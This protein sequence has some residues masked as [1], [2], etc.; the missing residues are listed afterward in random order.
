MSKYH[1]TCGCC[2]QSFDTDHKG[3]RYC[4]ACPPSVREAKVKG[5]W[6]VEIPCSQCGASFLPLMKK[7]K[8]CGSACRIAYFSARQATQKN[9][10]SRRHCVVC[11][12]VFQPDTRAAVC[13]SDA[14]ACRKSGTVTAGA[15]C[16]V[17]GTAFRPF[18]SDRVCCSAACGAA[19]ARKRRDKASQCVECGAAFV[20]SASGVALRCATCKAG[21]RQRKKRSEVPCAC[22]GKPF[23]HVNATARFCSRKCS[24]IGINNEGIGRRED[25]APVRERIIEFVRTCRHTPSLEEICAG[26]DVCADYVTNRL[27]M[28][29]AD[30][31]E[32]AGRRNRSLFPSKFEER[33]YFA[34][35]DMGLRDTDIDR[36]KKF[37]GLYVASERWPLRYDFHIPSLNILVEA[38]G[39]QH[40]KSFVYFGGSDTKDSDRRK[41]AYAAEHGIRLV[42]IPYKAT[43]DMVAKEVRQRLSAFVQQ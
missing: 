23:E 26:A 30:I 33:V 14:C 16:V 32:A 38:D 29:V 28:S 3:K 8:F 43:F 5:A 6:R 40:E 22:C 1:R 11:G 21:R 13:C 17:C 41:D 4:D 2:S 10:I 37:P 25:P 36:Q 19:R 31:F 42:R 18:K 7:S 12:T 9:S 15:F 34:L 20:T 24:A 35:L 39:P 27:H